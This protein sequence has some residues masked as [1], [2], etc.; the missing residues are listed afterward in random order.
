MDAYWHAAI[1]LSVGQDYLYDNPLLKRSL[2]LTD[3]KPMPLGHWNTTAGQNF[4]YVHVNLL[5]KK[6]DLEMVPVS[7]PGHGARGPDLARGHVQ[8]YLP[9]HQPGGGGTE[10]TVHRVLAPGGIPT[11][12]SPECPGSTDKGG[13]PGH[14][15]S[16]AFGECSTI[17]VSSSPASSAMARRKP[18]CWPSN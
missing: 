17:L 11:H 2:T 5:I 3:V 12:A 8:R 9:Q 15:L 16:H 18:V 4:I 7:A 6:Y 14:S 13:E 10:K 1:Y